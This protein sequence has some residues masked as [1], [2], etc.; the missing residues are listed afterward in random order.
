MAQAVNDS[1]FAQQVIA[2]EK[3]VV[4]DFWA[5]WCGPCRMISPIMDEMAEKFADKADIYKCNVDD[6]TDF[7]ANYG[8]RNIPTILFFKEGKV[9]DRH[10]G[11]ITKSALEAK[12]ASLI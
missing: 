8:V 9:I 3:L 6:C 1:N 11:P 2:S 5:T 7:P 12:I 10:V 4:V